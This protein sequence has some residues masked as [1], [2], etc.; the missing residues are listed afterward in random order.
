MAELT[1]DQ[2]VAEGIAH[3]RAG[4]LPEAEAAYRQALTLNPSH[5]QAL[6]YMGV[7]ALQIGDANWAV[8]L[9]SAAVD[10]SARDVDAHSNLSAALLAQGKPDEAINAAMRAVQ[11]KPDHPEAFANLGAALAASGRLD[12]AVAYFTRAVRIRPTPSVYDKLS[13]AYA[14]LG[15]LSDAQAARDQAEQLRR[16]K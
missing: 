5:F 7:L 8:R 15:K 10:V 3:Q 16:V 1:A 9:I 2:H 11:L 14:A 13:Q 12:E 6:H 4:R